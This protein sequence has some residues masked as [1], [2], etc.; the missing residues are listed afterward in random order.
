MKR[1]RSFFVGL[2]IALAI[3]AF[4]VGLTARDVWRQQR[5]HAL[6]LAIQRQDVEGVRSLLKQGADPNTRYTA[7]LDKSLWNTL[8]DC[9]HGKHAPLATGPSALLCALLSN[10]SPAQSERCNLWRLAEYCWN[11]ERFQTRMETQRIRISMP[12]RRQS[13]YANLPLPGC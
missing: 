12:S 5:N 2:G 13:R 8:L 9:L 1:R 4:P 11:M 7:E 3:L 10:P 6:L